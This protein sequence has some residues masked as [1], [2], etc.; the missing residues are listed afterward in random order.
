[1]NNPWTNLPSE[2]PYYLPAE[3]PF[4]DLYNRDAHA[5]HVI[6]SELLPEPYLGRPDAPVVLLNLNPGFDEREIPFHTKDKFFIMICRK[7]LLHQDQKYPFYLLDPQISAS[8][9][10]Q[11]WQK[12]LRVPIERVGIE[13]VA[14]KVLCLEYF[15]YHSK[16]Y[17]HMKKTFASQ[18]YTFLLAK[19][20]IRRNAMIIIM[21]SSKTWHKAL[22]QLAAY[23]NLFTLKNPQNVT[24]SPGNLPDGFEKLISALK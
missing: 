7:N 9:G 19:E 2:P 11:W 16:S 3:K 1:M 4:I 22:P 24:I 18:A 21:R 20:S 10:S 17:K 13:R 12:K 6:R 5:D 23:P 8:L 15:P 14:N